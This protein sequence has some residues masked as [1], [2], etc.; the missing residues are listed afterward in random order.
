MDTEYQKALK[1]TE[2]ELSFILPNNDQM[3]LLEIENIRN[4]AKARTNLNID[5]SK[6]SPEEKAWKTIYQRITK[7]IKDTYGKEIIDQIEKIEIAK[8]IQNEMISAVILGRKINNLLTEQGAVI[9]LTFDDEQNQ[10]KNILKNFSIQIESNNIN[11]QEKV[12]LAENL[13]QAAKGYEGIIVNKLY[14]Q[15][16]NIYKLLN[17]YKEIAKSDL[18][19]Q[20]QYNDLMNKWI[21]LTDEIYQNRSRVISAIKD[22]INIDIGLASI[23]IEH[24]G[25]SEKLTENESNNFIKDEKLYLTKIL[26]GGKEEE[27]IKK[28]RDPLSI[29][30]FGHPDTYS[31]DVTNGL[32]ENTQQITPDNDTTSKKNKLNIYVIL[33][34]IILIIIAISLN[35]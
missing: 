22:D 3:T 23:I 15:H 14:T 24:K 27:R 25:V 12:R 21:K 18:W 8:E 9:S 29:Q 30:L 4:Y 2:E 11:N 6:L 10:Y 13:I 5:E 20:I 31:E 26:V 1:K 32:I 34:I 7:T 28:E 33:L 16:E 17:E 19:E 35:S